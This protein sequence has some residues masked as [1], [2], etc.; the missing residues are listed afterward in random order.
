MA[1]VR[2]CNGA[3]NGNDG[4]KSGQNEMLEHK[5]LDTRHRKNTHEIKTICMKRNH[6]VF[7]N[8][9]NWLPLVQI[10]LKIH[11]AC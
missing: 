4:S 2:V 8:K 1:V 7:T 11:F 5:N 9:N 6:F 10:C 3:Y